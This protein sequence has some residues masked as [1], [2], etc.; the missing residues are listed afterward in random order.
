MHYQKIIVILM[1]LVASIAGLD[2]SGPIFATPDP[3]GAV[4][5]VNPRHSY[6]HYGD[7]F[8]VNL[9]VANV[10]DLYAWQFKIR[11][12]VEFFEAIEA[13]YP[14]DYVFARR[15]NALTCDP[16]IENDD[17]YVKCGASLMGSEPT[18]SGNGTLANIK[19]VVKLPGNWTLRLNTD[20][21]YLLDPSLNEISC[22]KTDGYV[23][24]E[25]YPVPK[26]NLHIAPNSTV[27]NSPYL[28]NTEYDFSIDANVSYV[29]GLHA[30]QITILYNNT[31]LECLNPTA[32]N[33]VGYFTWSYSLA[34]GKFI[35]GDAKLGSILFRLKSVGNS[36]ILFDQN[37]THLW[38]PNFEEIPY[39]TAEGYVD[40]KYYNSFNIVYQY[41][42]YQSP[43]TP[44]GLFIYPRY[45]FAS[46]GQNFTV[47]VSLNLGAYIWQAGILYNSTVLQVRRVWYTY[48]SHIDINLEPFID[49]SQGCVIVGGCPTDG[50]TCYEGDNPFIAL[51]GIEFSVV[52]EGNGLL[53][54]D[55][56]DSFLMDSDL[57]V[58]DCNLTDG[59]FNLYANASEWM[60]NKLTTKIIKKAG[61]CSNAQTYTAVLYSS[62]DIQNFRL[63]PVARKI[64]YDVNPL[65]YFNTS[66]DFSNI[67]IS[68]DALNQKFRVFIDGNPTAYTA[69]EN[70][71][72]ISLNFTY[73]HSAHSFLLETFNEYSFNVSRHGE[74]SDVHVVTDSCITGFA[75]DESLEQMS[76]NATGLPGTVGYSNVTFPKNLL[77]G[78]YTV[79]VNNFATPYTLSENSTHFF[80]Y[81]SYSHSTDVIKMMPTVLGDI[82]GDRK[83]DIR[84][85]AIAALAYGSFPGYPKW[86]PIADIT[87]SVYL[88]PDSRIDIRDIA[89]IASNYG[90]TYA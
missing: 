32:D 17:G 49:N 67:T 89:L 82:T 38:L 8:I 31:A 43:P 11:F 5:F 30:W 52:G 10:V 53:R 12:D 42:S 16:A 1:S 66:C 37:K 7:S 24:A 47:E 55:P 13:H 86:N 50:L 26:P 54:L 18:F 63:D 64:T 33:R 57:T 88:K 23:L 36:T 21:T 39:Q 59:H 65:P 28:V 45:S 19:F 73:T 34:K 85:I 83:V 71:T 51:A 58:F 25:P 61:S 79:L 2:F 74:R 81:F 80:I 70:V 15:D 40:A 20:D 76:F 68:K 4:I 44:P 69:W 22:S 27:I 72:Y 14:S 87:G 84:D 6:L 9:S 90:K 3:H 56:H 78:T 77:N 75:F 29:Y 60:V 62:S 48:T 35:I 41:R 46:K